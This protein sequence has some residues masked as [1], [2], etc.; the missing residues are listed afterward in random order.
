MKKLFL[1]LLIIIS[2]VHL[3]GQTAEYVTKHVIIAIDQYPS[4]SYDISSSCSN[5]IKLLKSLDLKG[6]D[7]VSIVKFGIGTQDKSFD[8]YASPIILEDNNYYVWK[9][10]KSYD[11]ISEMWNE[12]SN[13]PHFNEGRQFSMLTGAKFYSLSSLY[14]HNENNR[15]NR[16]YML[17]VTDNQY[18]GDG[19]INAEYSHFLHLDS[20]VAKSRLTR[21]SFVHN[22]IE[23]SK[24]Y[25][26]DYIEEEIIDGV[27]NSQPYE[28]FLF[29][30]VPSSSFSINSVVNY[31]ANMG[32]ERVK[33]GYK[34][35]FD[36]NLVDNDYS[37]ARL[38]VDICGKVSGEYYSNSDKVDL[39]IKSSEISCDSL[40]VT[41]RGWLH[42]KDTLY[43]A[44][45]MNPYDMDNFNGLTHTQYL[46][47]SDNIK[48]MNVL[49]L[50]DAFWWWYPN[51]L[52]KAVV[53]WDV[54]ILIG[55][56]ILLAII[57]Y[58][59]LRRIS[60]YEPNDNDIKLIHM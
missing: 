28:V 55:F 35:S 57:F 20:R 24:Y 44:V 1:I 53:C 22:C 16:T 2:T 43:G 58:F 59:V 31:P 46:P 27:T 9:S 47:L 48:I 41:I 18:N 32:L 3:F 17:M 14:K 40:T 50:Y 33:N 11:D 49:P 45:V 6:Y 30:V 8:S 36:Y 29:E 12:I 19:D 21:K 39:F 5:V 38:N 60:R 25:R 42:K 56:T 37:V 4:S 54:I 13:A 51:D 34:I 10:F 7:Y 23:V 15:A 52:Q 26:F